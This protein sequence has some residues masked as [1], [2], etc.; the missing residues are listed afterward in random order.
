MPTRD[1]GSL[2]GFKAAVV[3]NWNH[4]DNGRKEVYESL[5]PS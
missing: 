3:L 4:N 2:H 5:G 1:T